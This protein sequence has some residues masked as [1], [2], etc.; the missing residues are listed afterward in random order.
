MTSDYENTSESS[1]ESSSDSGGTSEASGSTEMPA[2]SQ[3]VVIPV[4]LL[5]LKIPAVVVSLIDS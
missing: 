3:V 2:M 5:D 1:S 4:I